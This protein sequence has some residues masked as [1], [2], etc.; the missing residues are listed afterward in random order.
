LVRDFLR[1]RSAF[2]PVAA[3]YDPDL[4]LA[5]ELVGGVQQNVEALFHAKIAGVDG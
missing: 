5:A 4:G 1:E 3:N 2:R